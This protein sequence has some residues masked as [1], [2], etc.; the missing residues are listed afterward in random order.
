V[1]RLVSNVVIPACIPESEAAQLLEEVYAGGWGFNGILSMS[2]LS[3]VFLA[4]N[5]AS[6]SLGLVNVALT[7]AAQF[8]LRS[9]MSIQVI[10]DSY[11]YFI[12][13]PGGTLNEQIPDWY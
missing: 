4:F 9:I 2:A 6:V 5:A 3:C 7:A 1:R 13:T 10:K 12:G 8:G 11:L